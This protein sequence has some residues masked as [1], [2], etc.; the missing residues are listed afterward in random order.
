MLRQSP[1]FPYE[2]PIELRIEYNYTLRRFVDELWYIDNARN[3]KRLVELGPQHWERDPE[4]WWF[5][6]TVW[7]MIKYGLE[8]LC[9]TGYQKSIEYL[10]EYIGHHDARPTLKD[11]IVEFLESL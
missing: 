5:S 11:E 6:F 9:E 3:E 10:L 4:E 8:K 7:D 2:Y 1:T